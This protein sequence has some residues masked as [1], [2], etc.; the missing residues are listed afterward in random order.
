MPFGLD[1]L[2]GRF[3]SSPLDVQQAGLGEY[4][5]AVSDDAW[6][7]NPLPSLLRWHQRNVADYGPLGAA[8]R[9]LDYTR[10]GLSGPAESALRALGAGDEAFR[11][12][13]PWLTKDEVQARGQ[14]YGLKLDRAMSEEA[15]NS[16]LDE[17]RRQL[18][19]QAVFD[20][21][22]V[23]DAYGPG[24]AALS[25]LLEF[26][27]SAVDPI[28]LATAFV[29]VSRVPFIARQLERVANVG[30]RRVAAGALEGAVGN[31]AA[32]GFSA[33]ALAD[34]DPNYGWNAA[35][36]DVAFGGALGGGLH[37]LGGRIADWGARPR[38]TPGPAGRAAPSPRDI[39]EAGA[40]G[41]PETGAG[42]AEAAR[43]ASDAIQGA[44]RSP[45]GPQPRAET[46]QPTARA[47][48]DL[49]PETR[50]ALYATALKQAAND[51][52]VDVDAVARLDPRFVAPPGARTGPAVSWGRMVDVAQLRRELEDQRSIL[53]HLQLGADRPPPFR[54]PPGWVPSP[55]EL[56]AARAVKTAPR[57]AA[58]PES[59]ATFVRRQGGLSGADPLAGDLRAQ[60]VGRSLLRQAGQPF[61]RMGEA[62][63]QAGFFKE[64]PTSQ[65][66]AAALIE[67]A[68]GRRKL[69]A[70][71]G[72]AARYLEGRQAKAAHEAARQHPVFGDLAALDERDLAY[73]MS[74]DPFERRL[75]EL[76]EL[77]RQGIISEAEAADRAWLI[78]RA[79]DE[80][81]A[82]ALR[83]ARDA[84]VRPEGFEK[85]LEAA[86][87]W[88]QSRPLTEQEHYDLAQRSGLPEEAGGGLPQGPGRPGDH[89]AAGDRP[90]PGAAAQPA[91]AAAGDE[92]SRA[93]PLDVEARAA[94]Q[95]LTDPA[96]QREFESWIK[97][98]ADWRAD[99]HAE[100]DAA[101]RADAAIADRAAITPEQDLAELEAAAAPLLDKDAKAEIAAT[102]KSYDEAKAM[103]DA[104]AACRMG[105]AG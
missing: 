5:D 62:A 75:I 82:Q 9:Y 91:A 70:D 48:E 53:E 11:P 43:A 15:L 56:A 81:E 34:E 71:A 10:P 32:E 72:A 19:N 23:G 104:Y 92:V 52:A 7:R 85:E 3:R 12:A 26:A 22:R 80:D 61:D 64:R 98:Q 87:E 35:L 69:Y 21:A 28:N 95:G 101:A 1:P 73:L 51:L 38:E 103:T 49:A 20:R 36:M 39:L 30:V 55:G 89:G 57:G 105:G 44:Q 58:E 46:G 65:D 79:I 41:G 6:S 2:A 83:E 63:Q 93:G 74:R 102:A 17:R 42:S 100:I 33:L 25:V 94:A 67:D 50:Q 13:S 90:A 18:A 40:R 54:A 59:L 68:A 27:V 24:R 14:P 78:D 99:A 66:F 16:I 31:T 45:E 8:M 37:W 47:I 60:D 97:R 77:Q 96:Y 4:L 84:G 76:D 29:P 86:D 88:A